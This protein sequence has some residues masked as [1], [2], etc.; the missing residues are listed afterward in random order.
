[1]DFLHRLE[2]KVEELVERHLFGGGALSLSGI[3]G[4]LHQALVRECL[5]GRE[6][7]LAPNLFVVRINPSEEEAL[8]T[9]G[10][11]FLKEMESNLLAELEGRGWKTAAPIRVLFRPDA[12]VP[13]GEFCLRADF[14]D[15]NGFVST[16]AFLE[17]ISGY[18]RGRLFLVRDKNLLGRS[19]QAHLSIGDPKVTQRHALLEKEEGA[20]FLEDLGSRN[21]TF[22]NGVKIER[23]ELKNG[24]ELRLGDT[25]L[26]FTTKAGGAGQTI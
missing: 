22:V 21:G 9:L 19:E 1:M 2:K 26:V 10:E 8:R 17:F 12:E 23:T 7:T 6:K 20:F 24:D 18:D 14:S 11:S 5:P 16:G 3:A 13:K 25:L 4:S 15:S